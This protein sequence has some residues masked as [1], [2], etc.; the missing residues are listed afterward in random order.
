MNNTSKKR[1]LVW[2]SGWVDSAVAAHLLLQQGYDVTA[3]FMINYITDSPDCTTKAD[4]EEAKRVAA[5]LGIKLHTFDFQKE[6]EE[7]IVQYIIHGYK[8]WITPNPDVLCNSDIKFKLFLD[9]AIALGFDAIATG[10]YVQTTTDDNGVVHLLKWVDP[11]KDQSYFLSRLNQKQLSSALFPVGGIPKSQVRKIAR[12]AGLPNAE[13]KDSQGIC[14]IG[15]V[16]MRE[17]LKSQ[18]EPK[19]GNIVNMEWKMLGK[20]QGAWWYTIGQRQGLGVAHSEPLFVIKKDVV[21]NTLVVGTESEAELYSKELVAI[22]WRWI[23]VAPALPLAA[24]AKIRYRQ[25]DQAC[26]I[27]TDSSNPAAIHVTFSEPQ[28]AV[29]SGQIV[30]VYQGDE[31]LG[32]WLIQ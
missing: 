25:A 17:F 2:L 16:E 12:E 11:E 24:N 19:E 29:A 6:Y 10:H 3:G 28:R 20:H 8:N 1:I 32:S 15:K 7:R 21:S 9:E 18:I 13:R 5:F 27:S 23:G 4:L 22:E 14:F 30:A 31:L 26:V